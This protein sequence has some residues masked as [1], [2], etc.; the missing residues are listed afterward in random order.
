MVVGEVK[1]KPRKNFRVSW[2]GFV[3]PIFVIVGTGDQ[4]CW[5]VGAVG[6]GS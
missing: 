4:W 2:G 3:V 1:M 6:P 5:S